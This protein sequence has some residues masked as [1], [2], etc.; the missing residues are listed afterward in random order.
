[1]V[2]QREK[3]QS[4]AELAVLMPLLL[5]ILLGCLDLGRAFGVW[6]ALANG[7]REGAR[8]ACLHPTA[9]LSIIE[10]VTTV[11]IVAEGLDVSRLAVSRSMPEA[12]KTGHPVIITAEYSLPMITG[13][14]FGGRP[15]TIR[16][17]TSMVIIEGI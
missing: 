15:L 1:M 5:M 10:E 8:Y 2:R 9:T 7:T 12:A 13:F 17:S 16:A 3:G 14:L 4:V 11:D 6:I